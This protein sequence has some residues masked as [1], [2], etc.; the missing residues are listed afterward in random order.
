ML[1]GTSSAS[2]RQLDSSGISAWAGATVTSGATI[3][4]ATTATPRKNPRTNPF[5]PV[6]DSFAGVAI[7]LYPVGLWDEHFPQVFVR[8]VDSLDPLW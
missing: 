1:F 7:S 6:P 2:A 8:A 3:S 4:N 5:C